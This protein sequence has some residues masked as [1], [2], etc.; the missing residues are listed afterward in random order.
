MALTEKTV[1]GSRD[2]LEDGQ[3]QVRRDT[4]ILKDGI[5]ISRTYHRHV[6]APGDDISTEDPSVQLVAKAV[7]TP[8][9][10]AAYKLAQRNSVLD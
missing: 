9:L 5:E 8:A 4:V 6:V 2:V 1:I 3:I 7:H 10:V